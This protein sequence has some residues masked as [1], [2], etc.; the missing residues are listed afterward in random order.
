ML[1]FH[2]QDRQAI[3]A[4]KVCNRGL[5]PNCATDLGH[6]LACKEVHEQLAEDSHALLLRATTIQQ[7][8]GRS[9]FIAPAFFGFMGVVFM[10]AGMRE[11]ARDSSFPLAMGAGFIVFAA[12]TLALN[13][14]AYG[15]TK[16]GAA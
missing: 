6:S 13:L 8:A 15:R 10:G 14:R 9:K 4:C 7:T 11:S 12:I 3:G 2:H 16:K 1:C 5:C